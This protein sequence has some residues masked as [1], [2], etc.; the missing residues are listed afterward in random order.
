MPVGAWINRKNADGIFLETMA[1]LG[2]GWFKHHTVYLGLR[3][4][5][6]VAWNE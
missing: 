1:A 5:G 3:I 4:G 6:W 2:V